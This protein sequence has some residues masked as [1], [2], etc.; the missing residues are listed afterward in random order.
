LP[1][2]RTPPGR[3][4]RTGAAALLLL[5]AAA[6]LVLCVELNP[7]VSGRLGGALG[8]TIS[9]ALSPST[10]KSIVSDVSG[11][12]RPK[13]GLGRDDACRSESGT[14]VRALEAVS[15]WCVRGEALSRSRAL[16]K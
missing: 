7:E 1:R 13:R 16:M 11:D 8:N 9:E 15:D 6:P 14:G 12:E 5:A 4:L 3:F 10:V 2:F